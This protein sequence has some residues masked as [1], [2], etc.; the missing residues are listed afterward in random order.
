MTRG[1]R[2]K[3]VR[4]AFKALRESGRDDCCEVCRWR[5]P[6][7]LREVP[8]GMIRRLLH[9]HHI[10]P[11]SCG[12][13][14]SL[15]NLILLCP[16]H[17]A[18]AHHIGRMVRDDEGTIVWTGARTRSDFLFAMELLRKPEEW[19]RFVRLRQRRDAY[20]EIV[21]AE[22]LEQDAIEEIRIKRAFTV[23]RG[24]KRA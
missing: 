7:S 1:K 6:R 2:D 20:T 14:D 19:R 24:S 17:H 13:A 3:R 9:A 18:V 10:V 11:V 4:V 22:A 5:P 16:N 12:G 21:Y 23:V 8:G 15:E